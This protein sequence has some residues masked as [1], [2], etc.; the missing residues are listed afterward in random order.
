MSV[1]PLH[2]H[3]TKTS[4]SWYGKITCRLVL[5]APRSRSSQLTSAGGQL[6]FQMAAADEGT[7]RCPRHGSAERGFNAGPTVF[8]ISNTTDS[9][10][11]NTAS[12]GRCLLPQLINYGRSTS[13]H[14]NVINF[15]NLTLYFR[16]D[17]NW[18]IHTFIAKFRCQR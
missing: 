16:Q 4:D 5:K 1:N 18:Y 2:R 13:V 7:F 8:F 9:I 15:E 10:L 12:V 3:R 6:S 17:F 14:S 11:T